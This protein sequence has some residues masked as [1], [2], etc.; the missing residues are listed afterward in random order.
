MMKG[1]QNFFYFFFFEGGGIF[2]RIVKNSV[3]EEEFQSCIVKL[4][5]SILLFI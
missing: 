1:T 5:F 3:L 2:K 4:Y